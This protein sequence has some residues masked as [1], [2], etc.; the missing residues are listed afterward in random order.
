MGT[1]ILIILTI[2][3]IVSYSIHYY[4]SKK[5]TFSSEQ[6][7]SLYEDYKKEGINTEYSFPTR[8]KGHA[9]SVMGNISFKKG[10]IY[11][12]V[13]FKELSVKDSFRLELYDKNYLLLEQD[14]YE[15]YFY[16]TKY[17]FITVKKNFRGL[18][19]LYNITPHS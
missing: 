6:I 15:L 5:K 18:I 4:K 16:S 12:L 9:E 13:F 7:S 19:S 3:A 11:K 8:D 17:C 14:E 2:V 10:K 1:T